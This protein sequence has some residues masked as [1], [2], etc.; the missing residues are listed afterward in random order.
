LLAD[1][2]VEG[3]AHLLFGALQSL[4]WADLLD[5]HLAT[6]A[7]IGLTAAAT[8]RE[9]WLRAQ[10]DGMLL[11]TDNRNKSGQD[12]LEQ[13]LLNEPSDMLLPVLTVG[14]AQRLL[15]DHAYREACAERIAE[16]VLDLE[17]YRGIPRLY[18]P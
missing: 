9:V 17:T 13:T 12:S 15:I 10:A 5:L 7:D 16:I 8:D 11:L 18:I 6:F 14:R 1:H 4:G 3:Q 2:N